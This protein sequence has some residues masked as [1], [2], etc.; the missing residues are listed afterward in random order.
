MPFMQVGTSWCSAVSR[1]I[2]YTFTWEERLENVAL[3]IF[4]FARWIH[5]HPANSRAGV[6]WRLMAPSRDSQSLSRYG[7]R[8]V[9]RSY[10]R[11]YPRQSCN[12]REG[13]TDL[14]R[15]FGRD[16]SRHGQC[17]LPDKEFR[18]DCYST[19][20]TLCEPAI[21]AG[22]CMSPYRSDFLFDPILHQIVWRKVSGDPACARAP[23]LS[24]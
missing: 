18:S 7:D 17:D 23:G 11:Y 15:S 1:G 20:L 2:D 12:C 6:L 21:S 22:F 10:P 13:S 3:G 19:A 8:P 9:K 5:L 14:S 24:C 4:P 16:C